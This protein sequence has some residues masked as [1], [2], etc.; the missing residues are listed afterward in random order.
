VGQEQIIPVSAAK[1]EK[2][3]R[4]VTAIIKADPALLHGLGE[5]MPR[6]R[7]TLA[8]QWILSAAGSAGVIGLTPLPLVDLI[9]LTVLQGALVL[10]LAGI[11]GYRITLARAK[12][13]VM[14]FGAG[15][16]ARTLFEQLSKLGGVPGW[17]LAAAIAASTT[18]A[19]GFAAEKWFEKGEKVTAAKISELAKQFT[20]NIV[21]RLASLGR[22]KP[23]KEKLEGAITAALDETTER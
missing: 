19:I 9:P 5:I 20:D 8:R 2:I 21:A 18:A 6:Y 22:K 1:G 12:E 10:N 17:I 23:A 14:T 15:I 7:H 3:D 16:A 11:Y 13:L 4:L